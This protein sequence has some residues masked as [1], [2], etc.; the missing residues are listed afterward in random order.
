MTVDMPPW[1]V[2]LLVGL[3]TLVVLRAMDRRE[4]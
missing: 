4:P 2:A 3:T 1:L